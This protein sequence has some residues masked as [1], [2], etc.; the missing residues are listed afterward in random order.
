MI[1]ID[2]SDGLRGPTC[3]WINVLCRNGLF[4]AAFQQFSDV[5]SLI[6]LIVYSAH[7]FH[8]SLLFNTQD[9]PFQM[10]QPLFPHRQQPVQSIGRGICLGND[11]RVE[12]R[13]EILLQIAP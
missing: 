6:Y 4:N 10:V 9:L 1:C 2:F 5:R 13:N 8:T 3:V 12:C 7:E 11:P